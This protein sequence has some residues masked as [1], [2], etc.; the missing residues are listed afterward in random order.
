MSRATIV[1]AALLL[2]AG[3]MPGRVDRVYVSSSYAPMQHHNLP[4]THYLRA[5]V[6]GNPFAIE[7]SE[8]D[9]LVSDAI[10]PR[11]DLQPT[12]A[13]YRVRLAFNGPATTSADHAC[14]TTG[15][16]GNTGGEIRLIAAFCSG[17]GQALTYLV[18][19]V[20]GITGAHDPR[21]RKFVRWAIVRLF[22]PPSNDER[23]NDNDMCWMIG[24]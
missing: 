15:G 5:D 22:P 20:S 8:F 2:L 1:V 23:D 9:A 24:C 3:C 11:P 19:S 17:S 6:S 21:F 14:G 13:G 10:Q 7:Q 4:R 18:G 16:T 12:H